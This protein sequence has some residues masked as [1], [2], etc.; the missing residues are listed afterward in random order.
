MYYQDEI[1][2]LPGVREVIDD[3]KTAC[4]ET[5]IVLGGPLGLDRSVLERA[6]AVWS[7]SRLTFPHELARLLLIEQIYRGLAIQRGHRYHRD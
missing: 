6:D 4:P 2:K 1:R 3:I 7:L 5:G